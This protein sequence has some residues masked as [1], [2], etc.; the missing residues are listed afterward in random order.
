[1]GG[2]EVVDSRLQQVFRDVLADDDLVLERHTTAADVPG[3]DS[4]AHI[5]LMF[6]VE[7]E[8]GITFRDDQ[9]T[10][11]R[12]VGELEDFVRAHGRAMDG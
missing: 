5:N 3:W 4:L 11:F 8:F 6:A 9:L 12:D 7:Q 2:I 1:M 10:S